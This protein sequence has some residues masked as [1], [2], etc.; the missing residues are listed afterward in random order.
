MQNNQQ[1]LIEIN[2]MRA[3]AVLLVV[4]YHAFPSWMP[5]G[6]IGVDIFFVISGFVISRGYLSRLESGDVSFPDFYKKRIRRL[7]PASLTLI[8]FTTLASMIILRPDN[9]I[10]YGWSVLAQPLFLQNLVFWTEGDYFSGPLNKPLLHTWSLAVEEQ[11]YLFWPLL[12]LLFRRTQKWMVIVMLLCALSIA[13]SFA[14]EV[15]SPKT[16]FYLLPFRAWQFGLGMIAFLLISRAPNV[17]K[18]WKNLALAVFISLATMAS[19]F[20]GD[21][22][23]LPSIGNLAVSAV[24]ATTLLII[25]KAPKSASP[26]FAFGPLPYLGEVSYSFYLWHWPPLS[27]FFLHYGRPASYLEA[28][29]LMAGALVIAM[30]SYHFVENPIRY[31]HRIS[32]SR[33]VPVWAGS[34]IF[35]VLVASLFIWSQGLLVR[36]SKEVRP[37]L[38]A[39]MEADK[40]R[41][42]YWQVATAPHA[43]TC[44]LNRAGADRPTVLFVGDSHV[45]VI[46]QMLGELGRD[47]DVT[48]LLTVRN[49]DLGRFGSLQFCSDNVLD[50]L[51][52]EAD[53]KSVDAIFAMSYW[54][55]N[56]FNSETLA[57]DL[58]ALSKVTNN[59]ALVETVP[60]SADYHPEIRIEEHD[61]TGAIN[62]KGILRRAFDKKNLNIANELE[63]AVNAKST[64]RVLK[65]ADYLCP[66]E[67][68]LYS[69]DGQILYFDSNHLTLAGAQILR[70]MFESEFTDLES[71]KTRK[72]E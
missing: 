7:L 16:V 40:S 28:S 66:D 29:I 35:L 19:L 25:A 59:I 1:H 58:S 53:E 33:L 26:I 51:V 36:Y 68:C 21:W 64:M 31:G 18:A 6:F 12:I 27:L 63:M 32:P 72:I 23:K 17:T 39:S 15:R 30:L 11:F 47:K 44:Y 70:P 43:E 9:L 65:P 22:A 49:C 24:T 5:G 54:E 10:D 46:K 50:K 13:A 34:S 41:C 55:L 37:F 48:V 45:A 62:T 20:G 69:K 14:L 3:L 57:R 67:I 42:G 61:R 2:T 60:F 71:T 52:A 8:L 38:T 4:F 56:K